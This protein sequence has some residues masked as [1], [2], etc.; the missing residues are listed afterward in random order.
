MDAQEVEVDL[1]LSGEGL[2]LNEQVEVELACG[3]TFR[4][5]QSAGSSQFHR[6]VAWQLGRR[7]DPRFS[8]AEA[9]ELKVS[10]EVPG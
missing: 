9:G 4:D 8:L 7:R 1:D 5:L 3:G 10:F 6:A 2:T